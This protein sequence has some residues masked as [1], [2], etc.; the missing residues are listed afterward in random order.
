MTIDYARMVAELSIDEG[1]RLTVYD[2]V[3]GR[4]L[5]KGDRLEGHPT[6]GIGR[7]LDVNG[8][9]MDEA[10]R[11]LVNDLAY[12][13]A[14]LSKLAWF[15]A[16]D[17]VR[18]RVIVNMRHQLGMAGL[19][20]FKQMITAIEAHTYDVAANCMLASDWA[21][22]ETPARAKRLANIMANGAEPTNYGSS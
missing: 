10:K 2:D 21:R 12:Y 8:I 20:R 17:S 3:T 4:P 18:K 11:M 9:S 19:M 5:K 13:I 1:V 15:T 6:I 14:E 16:L 7:A 22:R